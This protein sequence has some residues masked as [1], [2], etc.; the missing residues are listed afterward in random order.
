[1]RPF[2]A[3]GATILTTGD[4]GGVIERV[5]ASPRGLRPD[6]QSRAARRPRIEPIVG[7]RVLE[8]RHHRLELYD[9]GPCEHVAEILVAYFPQ[10]E[11]LFVADL[12]DVGSTAMVLVGP[13]AVTLADEIRSLGLDVQRIVPVHGA[14]PVTREHLEQGLARRA[15]HVPA[16]SGS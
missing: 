7:S 8:D 4:A 10:H 6:A 11:L 9:L 3:E 12:F 2:V 14:A 5:A 16:A 13:D 1:V 15:R